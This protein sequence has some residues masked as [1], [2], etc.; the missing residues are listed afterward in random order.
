MRANWPRVERRFQFHSPSNS[1]ILVLPDTSKS[2][3]VL[4]IQKLVPRLTLG[5][6]AY[7]N[8]PTP[9]NVAGIIKKALLAAVSETF[10][11]R[12]KGGVETAHGKRL[13]G[14][15]FS[16]VSNQ[17]GPLA[18]P[19]GGNDHSVNEGS[20]HTVEG[21]R[22]VSLIHNPHGGEHHPGPKTEVRIQDEIQ[23]GLF[24]LQLAALLSPLDQGV[25]ELQFSNE[26]DAVVEVVSKEKH[27]TVEVEHGRIQVVM[28][29]VHF[30][31]PAVGNTTF[32]SGI[33]G[34]NLVLRKFLRG[35][36]RFPR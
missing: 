13:E 33:S 19:G 31:V 34:H 25:L 32:G 6:P 9:E 16:Q 24:Q 35:F 10:V 36:L 18:E 20:L 7:S 3:P 23:V 22:F 17:S 11:S 28:V 5:I 1:K 2:K 27:K 21:G 4:P 12:E 26:T 30:H 14:E 8:R 29:D 15:P